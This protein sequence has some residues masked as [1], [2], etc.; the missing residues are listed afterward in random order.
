M[1]VFELVKYL[2]IFLGGLG[3]IF[4]ALSL[5]AFLKGYDNPGVLLFAGL[6]LVSAGLFL[7]LIINKNDAPPQEQVSNLSSDSIPGFTKWNV[8]IGNQKTHFYAKGDLQFTVD[9]VKNS[10]EIFTTPYPINDD[11]VTMIVRDSIII[12]R[13]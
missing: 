3:A 10:I 5:V 12:S 1:S 9:S 4:L 7:E 11:Q 2:P 6:I 8:T 13:E